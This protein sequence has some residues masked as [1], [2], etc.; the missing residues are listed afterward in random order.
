MGLGAALVNVIDIDVDQKKLSGVDRRECD[1]FHVVVVL[2]HPV[3]PGRVFFMVI[4]Y[5]W[6]R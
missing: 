6:I 1:G 5:Q 3:S 4:I 2:S